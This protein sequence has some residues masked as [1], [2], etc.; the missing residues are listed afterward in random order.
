MVRNT[1]ITSDDWD[2]KTLNHLESTKDDIRGKLNYAL[3]DHDDN[4]DKKFIDFE[5]YEV[6]ENYDKID[7]KSFD[8]LYLRNSNN[9][10]Y[11]INDGCFW[12]SELMKWVKIDQKMKTSIFNFVYNSDP[13]IF[14]SYKRVLEVCNDLG[15]SHVFTFEQI[16]KLI[17]LK[18]DEKYLKNLFYLKNNFPFFNSNDISYILCHPYLLSDDIVKK[19]EKL[20]DINS[21]YELSKSSILFSVHE[22]QYLKDVEINDELEEKL[23]NI[24]SLENAG[25][26][27]SLKELPFLGRLDIDR[28]LIRKLKKLDKLDVSLYLFDIPYIKDLDINDKLVN[29]L[30]ALKKCKVS[31]YSSDLHMLENLEFTEWM[32][33]NLKYVINNRSMRAW[34]SCSVAEAVFISWLTKEEID[35]DFSVIRE[36]GCKLDWSVALHDFHEL[37]RDVVDYCKE[38]KIN[39]PWDV[40]TAKL[41]YSL[42]DRKSIQDYI[43][44]REDYLKD[45]KVLSDEKFHEY[46]WWKWKLNKYEINQWNLWLCYM[47]SCLELF[48]KMNWFDSFIQSNFIEE[49]DWWLVRIPLN[50]W[51]WIKVHKGEIDKKFDLKFDNS[52][53]RSM[54]INSYTDSLWLKV[55]EIAF[56]KKLIYDGSYDDAPGTGW[57]EDPL[58]TKITWDGLADIEWWSTIVAMKRLFWRNNVFYWKIFQSTNRFE[59]L[60]KMNAPSCVLNSSMDLIKSSYSRSEKLFDLHKTWLVAVELWLEDIDDDY[61]VV[62]DAKIVDKFWNEVPKNKLRNLPDVAIGKKWKVIRLFSHHAYSLEKC[63][64]D[65]DWNKIVRVV[66]PW[67]T[68]IKFDIPFETAKKIFGWDFWV[69]DINTLFK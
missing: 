9:L 11:S 20:F 61:I 1:I 50:T 27:I 45:N 18:L 8:E 47:Y 68:W 53:V 59:R 24:F 19:A 67:H 36:I 38:N 13:D 21:Y 23:D 37:P 69:I 35:E 41:F 65:T 32:Q 15:E 34:P 25:L 26:G 48:K 28:D 66:N 55:L 57:R 60:K 49:D 17:S 64:I 42:V 3:N 63:F 2:E 51:K 7:D 39:T 58:D 30:K 43:Q 54:N 31:V 33:Q 46:F 29:A 12:L 10:K 62:N 22:L 4:S 40:Y 52:K 5:D 56:I 16:L 6:D 44:R 14:A